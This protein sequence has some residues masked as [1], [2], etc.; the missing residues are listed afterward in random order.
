MQHLNGTLSRNSDENPSNEGKKST[1]RLQNV[2]G[3]LS[4]LLNGDK[5]V[6]VIN[7]TKSDSD[8]TFMTKSGINA[9]SIFIEKTINNI[10]NNLNNEF[11]S[12]VY[13]NRE[14]SKVD[15]NSQTSDKLTHGQHQIDLFE[16]NLN[17]DFIKTNNVKPANKIAA[18][19]K[20]FFE[21]SEF[22]RSTNNMSKSSFGETLFITNQHN[23]TPSF[24]SEKSKKSNSVASIETVKTTTNKHNRLRIN[25]LE[26]ARTESKQQYNKLYKKLKNTREQFANSKL[27][28]VNLKY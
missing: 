7:T 15:L 17:L 5:I 10:N 16:K 26:L 24:A 23:S 21:T 18:K 22:K 2:I 4:Q 11:D 13:I 27:K 14:L 9:S 20:S 25:L 12:M 28:N 19:E 3:S 8:K 6:S 1:S